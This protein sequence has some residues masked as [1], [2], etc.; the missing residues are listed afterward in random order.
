METLLRNAYT[1]H[2]GISQPTVTNLSQ[3]VTSTNFEIEDDENRETQIQYPPNKGT[4]VYRNRNSKEITIINYDKF[5]TAL[6]YSF[7]KGRKRCDLIVYTNQATDYFLLNELKNASFKSARKKAKKQLEESL[8][9]LMNVPSINTYANKFS[10]KR[11]CIFNKRVSSP[12]SISAG[13][14]FNRLSSITTNGLK[15]SNLLIEGH[16]F[17]LYEYTGGQIFDIN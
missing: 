6:D 2:Y 3:V 10:V 11:C 1:T 16:G 5:I 9:D 15:L 7:Q 13:T 17:E 4:A 12:P 8:N 14:A